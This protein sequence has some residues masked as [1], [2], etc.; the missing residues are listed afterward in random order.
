MVCKECNREFEKLD[1]LRKHRALKHNITSEQTYIDYVFNGIPPVCKCG[2]GEKPGYLS[3]VKGF[4]D[5]VWG[6]AARVNNNWGHNPAVVKKSHETQKQMYN[7]GTLQIWNKGLTIEDPR[8]R[9]NIDKVMANPE[10]GNNISKK[11]TGVAKS[12]EHKLNISKTAIIRW[13]NQDERIKQRYRRAQYYKNRKFNKKT[14]LEEKVENIIK[15]L[16]IEYEFQYPLDGYLF[17]FY[18]PEYNSLIEVDGDW[19]HCNPLKYPEMK[20]DIQKCVNKNDNIKNLLV[21]SK[22]IKLLRFWESDINKTPEEVIARL[23]QEF[24]LL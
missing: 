11:L 1:S 5:Y 6:H 7:D 21:E 18:L 15:S 23:K 19:Y 14:K 10:R 12:E 22:R 3:I 16:N 20:S 24:N 4:V 2:C 9:D 13:E 8:V 17:D